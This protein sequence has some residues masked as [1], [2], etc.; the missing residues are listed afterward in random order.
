MSTFG[1]SVSNFVHT[2]TPSEP[3][4]PQG[5]TV[6][7]F[8]HETQIPGNPVTPQGLLVSEFVHAI[9]G[10]PTEPQGLLVSS[11][12]HELHEPSSFVPVTSDYWMP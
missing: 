8:V 1:T 4:E 6:S 9:P 10:D 7:A 12:V 2:F 3:L 5:Q 11:F